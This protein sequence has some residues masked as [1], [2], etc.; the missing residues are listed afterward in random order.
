MMYW[1]SFCRTRNKTIV[2][3]SSSVKWSLIIPL[4]QDLFLFFSTT[5]NCSWRLKFSSYTQITSINPGPLLFLELFIDFFKSSSQL[6]HSILIKMLK[7]KK[8]RTKAVHRNTEMPLNTQSLERLISVN[9]E[10]KCWKSVIGFEV[11]KRKGY[12][13]AYGY[14]IIR[15][16]GY[17][18]LGP[19]FVS[20][21]S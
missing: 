14:Y 3:P 20:S 1:L 16:L 19:C 10:F 6:S 18:L 2:L 21:M 7:R 12:R 9:F 17:F 5:Q 8:I 11:N 4:P 13:N 15:G